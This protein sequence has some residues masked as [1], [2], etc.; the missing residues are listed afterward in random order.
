M[1]I[2]F[3]AFKMN[4]PVSS[5]KFRQCQNIATETILR[6]IP[7]DS[8]ADCFGVPSSWIPL[9]YWEKGNKMRTE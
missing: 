9:P 8:V 7:A 2:L 5:V 4:G 6:G 1:T 3:Y